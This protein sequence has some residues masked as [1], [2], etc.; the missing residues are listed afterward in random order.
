MP[1]FFQADAMIYDIV[2]GKDWNKGITCV[3]YYRNILYPL[4][5]LKFQFHNNPVLS[6]Q[7][8]MHFRM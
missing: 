6:P 7:Q 1:W 8:P 4:Q 5:S 3:A 2:I